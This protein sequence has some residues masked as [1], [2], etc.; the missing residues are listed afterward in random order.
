MAGKID[1]KAQSGANDEA[2]GCREAAL[3]VETSLKT[4]VYPKKML[5]MQ[6]SLQRVEQCMDAYGINSAHCFGFSRGNIFAIDS[7]T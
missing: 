2:R 4:N 5:A 7:V 1:T 6:A 3:K